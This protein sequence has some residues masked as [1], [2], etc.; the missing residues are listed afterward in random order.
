MHVGC[1]AANGKFVTGLLTAVSDNSY[2]SSY[3]TSTPIESKVN[4]KAGPL[5]LTIILRD[6]HPT[7]PPGP[8]H[9]P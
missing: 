4:H 5:L 6:C 2:Y 9:A 8:G 3:P 1:N 7:Q